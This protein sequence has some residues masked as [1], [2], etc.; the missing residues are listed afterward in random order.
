MIGALS[1]SGGYAAASYSPVSRFRQEGQGQGKEGGA[2]ATA[3]LKKSD[4]SN[5]SQQPPTGLSDEEQ[6]VVDKLKQ[7]EAGVRAHEQAHQM[8]GG[9]YAGS[10]SYTTTQG[11]D[12]KRYITG[13]EVSIDISPENDPQAT[14][15]KMDQVKRAALAPSDP[16]GQDRAVAQQAEAIKAQA[17]ADLNKQRQEKLKSDDEQSGQGGGLTDS[18]AGVSKAEQEQEGR[19]QAYNQAAQAYRSSQALI[20]ALQGI[21][22]SA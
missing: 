12:G 18:G 9:A 20:G 8:A 5:T 13:G 16:S 22:V 14:I 19:N 2:S 1:G 17:Q 3:D 6:R 7:R 4:K 10:P 15:S 21:G 11:P